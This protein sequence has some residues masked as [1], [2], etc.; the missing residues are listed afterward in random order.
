MG[1]SAS[2]SGIK[3]NVTDF[4][5]GVGFLPYW[6]DL[7]EEPQNSI[8]GGASLWTFRGHSKMEYEGIARFF[9]YLA[10]P[11]IQS[12]WHQSTGYLPVTFAAYEQ[13]RAEGFYE[14]NPGTDVAIRQLT[15][16]PPTAHSKGLRFGSFV[17]IRDVINS[18]L[19]AVWVGKKSAR[20]ALDEAVARGN[21]LLRKFE[22]ANR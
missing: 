14:R 9:S 8:I 17:Q 4:E 6:P 5:F 2:Y 15:R 3:E 10:S 13:T 1:S 18:E 7:V 19:E 21:V 11:Q 22:R 16:N 20:E 12:L